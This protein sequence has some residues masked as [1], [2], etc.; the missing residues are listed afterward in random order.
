DMLN[1]EIRRTLGMTQAQLAAVLNVSRPYITMV[2]SKMRSLHSTSHI[3]LA[4]MYLQFYELET[5][6]QAS[7]R[8]LETRLFMNDEYKRILPSLKALEEECR[9]KVKELKKDLE[10]MKERARDCENSII[11]F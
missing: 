3:L 9:R 4:N 10:K 7:Y 11:V 5:G 6:K 1:T 8:S 2:E